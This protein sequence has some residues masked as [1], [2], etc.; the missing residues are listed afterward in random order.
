[1][2]SLPKTPILNT[3]PFHKN[4]RIFLQILV[5]FL[6][7]GRAWQG[8]FWDLPLRAFFWNQRLLEGWVEF[9]LGM[10][11]QEYATDVEGVDRFI[12]NLNFSLGVFWLIC[13]VLALMIHLKQRWMSWILYLGSFTLLLLSALYWKEK[14]LAIGQFFEYSLQVGSPILLVYVCFNPNKNSLRFRHIVRL[15]ISVAFV[16][17]GLYAVG[18]YPQP[19]S[20]IQWSMQMFFIPSDAMASNFLKIMGWLDFVA[21]LLIWLP[22]KQTRN[23]ALW[24]CILWG[25]MTAL[26]RVTSNF[27]WE[28]PLSSL[29][30]WTYETLLRFVHGGIPL[31]LLIWDRKSS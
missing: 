19:G 6:F 27:Y 28:F 13:A 17:H 16:C 4:E 5:F 22:H 24:Y 9:F 7:L 21:A 15:L 8:I 31:L 3:I 2:F 29:H 12:N 18:F 11:W 10:D 23:A 20:W 1:M 26:A 14:F 25:F 30:Q